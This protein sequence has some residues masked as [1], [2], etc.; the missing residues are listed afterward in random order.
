MWV[1]VEV[2]AWSGPTTRLFRVS[3]LYYCLENVP[4]V[5]LSEKSCLAESNSI[6]QEQAAAN[7]DDIVE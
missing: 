4:K 3:E 7:A 5:Q 1:R 6:L 2:V